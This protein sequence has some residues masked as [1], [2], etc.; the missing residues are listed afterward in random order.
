MAHPT[1]GPFARRD[2]NSAERD[3]LTRT[4]AEWQE[5]LAIAP[6]FATNC[7]RAYRSAKERTR[8]LYNVAVFDKLLVRDGAIAEVKYREP[9]ELIFNATEFEQRRMERET[10]FE[11]ATSTLGRMTSNFEYK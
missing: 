5:I 9:F 3:F 1:L 8:K 6:K 2:R 7:A 4:L 11:L 10:R